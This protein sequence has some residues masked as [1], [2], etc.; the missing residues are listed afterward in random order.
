MSNVVSISC[1]CDYLVKRAARHRRAGRYD[2]AMALL[3]KA[4]NQFGLSDEVLL[5]MAQVYEAIGCEE[6]AV[7]TYLRLV[8]LGG[9]HKAQA[10]F[11][12]AIFSAQRGDMRRAASY[13]ENLLYLR[14]WDDASQE[15]PEEL[16]E[17]LEQQLNEDLRDASSLNAKK[18]ARALEKRAAAYLQE[19]KAVAAQ[20]AMEHSL[21]FRPTARGF[22]MLAC[23][24]LIRM[25]FDDAVASAQIAHDMS[26]GNV[27]TLCV[28][29]DAYMACGDKKRMRRT[30]YLASLRAHR[31]D[32]LLSV[33]V[34]SAKAGEDALT[35]Q[36]THRILKTAPFHT[37]A[38]MIRACAHINR[39]EYKAAKR[40]LGR[41]CGLLPE[42]SVCESYYRTLCADESFSER[43]SLGLDVTHEEGIRRAVELF[44][45]LS[46][47]P[48][49]ID[50]DRAQCLRICRL[51]G[52][53]FH[54]PM[55]GSTTKTV[56][57]VLVSALQSDEARGVLLDL[58]I[59]PQISDSI[60]LNVLQVLT[61]RDGFQPYDVDMD[62]KLVRLAA[63]GVSAKPIGTGNA[64]SKIVQRVADELSPKDRKASKILLDAF[65]AYL[66]AYGY[67]DVKHEDACA[68]ALEYW[69][70][71]HA[72]RKINEAGIAARYGV[73]V[74][75][76][77]AYV[78]RFESCTQKHKQPQQGE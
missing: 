17:A 43:L 25:R 68:A 33:A 38:M 78:R 63:G 56:A 44:S 12:L 57:L 2:E 35:L 65:L 5:E 3:W 21:H 42:D 13:F 15:I 61:A 14:D 64:N 77:R 39:H 76:M 54:S 32:D 51:C 70:H 22:T 48:K 71:V 55:A 59:H 58:L 28:L 69:Y 37:R 20:R 19:G 6:E 73:S 36:L 74:R 72:E 40:L 16:M 75:M 41:L 29:A 50:E 26:P 23:C 18:R 10:L 31:V 60:K 52:W 46:A 45:A 53:A 66:D 11:Q 30:I 62:G 34:E 9:P 24:Q 4:R 27:Q 7:R 49:T 47:D 1:T 67:P 8:R